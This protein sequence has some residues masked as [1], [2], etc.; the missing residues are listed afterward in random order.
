MVSGERGVLNTECQLWR[1]MRGQVENAGWSRKLRRE[2]EGVGSG[3]GK[4]EVAE[5]ERE[6]AV[7]GIQLGVARWE[8]AVGG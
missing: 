8:V 7:V 5:G 3:E 2:A 6:V 1:R 4:C